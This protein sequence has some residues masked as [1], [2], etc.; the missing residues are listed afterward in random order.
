MASQWN[1]DQD[2]LLKEIP[3][4]GTKINSLIALLRAEAH[5]SIDV[6]AGALVWYKKAL[7]LDV[8]CYEAWKK[9]NEGCMLSPDEEEH[10]LNSLPFTSE[11]EWLKGFY[12]SK[13]SKFVANY[14][15]EISSGSA[16]DAKI[17]QEQL[18]APSAVTSSVT[19]IS[20]ATSD[21]TLRITS[22]SKPNLP[23][24]GKKTAAASK[25]GNEVD[26]NAKPSS[27]GG[28]L[29]SKYALVTELDTKYK[30]ELN[31]DLI[32]A[33]AQAAFYAN[34]V[35]E[36]FSLTSS[37]LE[38]DPYSSSVL[39]IHLPC[40]VEL[41]LKNDLYLLAHRM[42]ENAPKSALSWYAV[43]CYYFLIKSWQNARLYFGKATSLKREFGAAWMAYGYTFAQN[44]EHDQA[45]FAYRTAARILVGS[46]LPNLLIATE[47][48]R[49]KDMVLAK[50][51]ALKSVSMQPR[52]PYP[53]HELAVILYRSQEYHQ[54]IKQFELV[55]DLVGK[56][57]MDA[58]WEPT[59]Y[60]LAQANIKIQNYDRAIE[61]LELSLAILPYNPSTYTLLAF[62]HH[63]QG[64][65]QEAIDYYH[66]ALSINPEYDFALLAI[67]EALN[68]WVLRQPIQA[69][70]LDD[71]FNASLLGDDLQ[72]PVGS[73]SAADVDNDDN[74]QLSTPQLH[75]QPSKMAT[76]SA[77]NENLS[78]PIQQS[79]LRN[80]A[81][82][83]A[84]YDRNMELDTSGTSTPKMQ[85]TP[86]HS[87]PPRSPMPSGLDT[88]TM[89]MES[90]SESNQSMLLDTSVPMDTSVGMDMEEDDDDDGG[91]LMTPTK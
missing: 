75:R 72:D 3:S 66:Q 59:L 28:K 71:E 37:V 62:A 26:S 29:S 13:T 27:G 35:R 58:T 65:L 48:T 50:Q 81:R 21:S 55:L 47:L 89:D 82:F 73:Q 68:E 53:I 41:G 88:S 9:L 2:S 30:L 8:T 6:R 43:G 15:I 85:E 36:A 40:L 4:T 7:E 79:S 63:I 83:G 1:E 33:K 69:I 17:G 18:L 90:G 54:A 19:S 87:L 49:T 78:T 52:D 61:L 74:P 16:L 76:A 32:A 11:L 51:Y 60:N 24:P 57:Q 20:H 86:T 31:E 22:L 42:A 12:L 34:R 23:V 77:I 45:F 64:N 38:R 67:E 91:M 39:M 80:Q 70:D 14:G 5:E 46:H 25:N 56:A 10:F 44:G 84:S